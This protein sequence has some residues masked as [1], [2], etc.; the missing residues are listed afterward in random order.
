M[1]TTLLLAGCLLLGGSTF[2]ADLTL[3]DGRVL[4]GASIMSQTPLNV[5]IRHAAG[6]SSVS[7]N[8]LPPELRAQYAVDEAGAKAAEARAQEAS[9]KAR[10]LQLTAAEHAARIR[11]QQEAAMAGQA[12]TAAQKTAAEKI[13]NLEARLGAQQRAEDY[14]HNEFEPFAKAD[15]VDRQLTVNISE[16]HLVDGWDN[17]WYVRGISTVRFTEWSKVS[18]VYSPEEVHFAAT[19]LRQLDYTPRSVPQY[20]VR[21]QAFEAVYSTSGGKPTFEVTLN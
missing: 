11:A 13:K 2:A 8:L 21:S 14:F 17:R 4:K 10:A 3:T 18:P 20:T 12:D 15:D 19:N 16:M 7:K 5:T 6:L 9:A 1:K